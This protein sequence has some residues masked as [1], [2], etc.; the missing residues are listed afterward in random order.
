VAVN[1]GDRSTE[2]GQVSR[3]YAVNEQLCQVKVV[4]NRTQVK[5]SFYRILDFS[6]Y[7]LQII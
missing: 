4:F 5:E 6:E 2:I 3:S 7:V 1:A